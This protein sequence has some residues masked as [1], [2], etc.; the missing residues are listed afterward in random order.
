[1]ENIDESADVCETGDSS[2]WNGLD[3]MGLNESNSRVVILKGLRKTSGKS[4]T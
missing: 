3:W 4:G 1:M 2:V